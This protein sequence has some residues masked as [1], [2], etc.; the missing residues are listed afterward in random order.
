MKFLELI[1]LTLQEL[2][3]K[4]V[5][6]FTDLVKPDHKKIISCVS[7][8]NN[9]ILNLRDWDFLRREGV[10]AIPMHADCVD[11]PWEMKLKSVN[12][13]GRNLDYIEDCTRFLLGEVVENAYSTFEGQLLLTPAPFKRVAKVFY[14]TKNH[15]KN[16]A[17][18]EVPRL[19]YGDDETLLPDEFA[20]SA[21]VYCACAQF[22]SNP[23]HPKY[24]HWVESFAAEQAKMVA[25]NESTA[26]AAPEIKLPRWTFGADRY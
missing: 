20:S 26:Y 8:A 9:R 12:I 14:I 15:A 10:L 1:N 2:N 13:D 24:R 4:T 16:A 21:L 3:Y 5:S 23:Q 17:G 7:L 22:K 18:A 19:V 25:A 11:L 6:A